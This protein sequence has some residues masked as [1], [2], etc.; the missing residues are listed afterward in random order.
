MCLQSREKAKKDAREAVKKADA[1]VIH[2][3]SILADR[4]LLIQKHEVKPSPI[5]YMKLHN[6]FGLVNQA[7]I[8]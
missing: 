2:N 5:D 6:Y 8:E 7:T 3:V 4:P 1:E